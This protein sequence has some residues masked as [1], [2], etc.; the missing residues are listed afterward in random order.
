M[1]IIVFDPLAIGLLIAS[2]YSFQSLRNGGPNTRVIERFY[3]V[4]ADVNTN[5]PDDIAKLEQ[6]LKTRLEK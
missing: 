3:E 5:T 4:E 6:K 2:Q 1:I